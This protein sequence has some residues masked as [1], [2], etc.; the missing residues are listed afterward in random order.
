M[1][2]ENTTANDEAQIRVLIDDWANALRAK[3]VDDVMSRYAADLVQF[4]MAPP[5]KYAGRMRSIGMA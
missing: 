2:T 1:T 5:L 4:V 3:D